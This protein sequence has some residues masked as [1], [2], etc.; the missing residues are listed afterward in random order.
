MLSKQVYIVTQ[1]YSD[2][3]DYPDIHGTELIAV[4]QTKE[5]AEKI[6]EKQN[7]KSVLTPAFSSEVWDEW[8]LY[9][10]DNFGNSDEPVNDEYYKNTNVSMT[11]VNECIKYF[12]NHS[13]FK[14][15]TVDELTDKIHKQYDYEENQWFTYSEC[16]ITTADYYYNDNN[17]EF[18]KVK[19]N[20]VG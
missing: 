6:A 10:D 11:E 5:I 17:F 4:C 12:Q 7:K 15:L 2:G 14:Q 19:N 1:D 13:D 9:F 8:I 18:L 3:L 16:E 20:A